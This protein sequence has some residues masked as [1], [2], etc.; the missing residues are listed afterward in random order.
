MAH[1]I[2]EAMKPKR[3]EKL[4]GGSVPAVEADETFIGIKFGGFSN[5]LKSESRGRCLW[6]ISIIVSII[7][8]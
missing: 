3:L 7:N 2:R 1:R 8:R 4:G 5:V 6:N